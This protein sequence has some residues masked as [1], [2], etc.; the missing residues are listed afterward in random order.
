MKKGIIIELKDQYTYV[1]CH[2]GKMKRIKRE[3]YHEVGQEIQVSRFQKKQAISIFIMTCVF[4]FAIVLQPF[5][6]SNTVKAL[7]YITLSVNPGLVFKVDDKQRITAVSY[8]N[9]EGQEMTQQI[10]FINKSLD[11]SVLFFID[12]C[13]ENGY[14]ANNQKIDINVVSDDT[15]QIQ[16]L[17]KQ[18][19]QLI[20]DYLKTHQMS[21]SISLDKV[22][23]SQQTEAKNLGIPDSKI[24]LIDLILHYYP[25]MNKE[26]LAKQSVDDLVEYLED[27]GYEEDMLER[28]EDHLEEKEEVN[29]DD[30]EVD[31]ND[32]NNDDNDT[33][34][35]EDND[36][37][38][39]DNNDEDDD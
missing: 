26:T 15:N 19:Q 18:I 9:K 29:D 23:P 25:H 21:I 7:S 6:S 24:K 3:Y 34:D 11:D 22:S 38:D 27:K 8:T 28:M 16:S 20:Q 1:L 5:Q 13:F 32:E 35:H 33:N 39:E 12:Y 2:N 30:N 14:F 37:N 10:D 31:N 4:I 17:E 36:D